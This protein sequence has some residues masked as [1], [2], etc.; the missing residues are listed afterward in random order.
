VLFQAY[1]VQYKDYIPGQGEGIVGSG[2]GIC[3]STAPYSCVNMP[4]IAPPL[5]PPVESPKA[6]VS[7]P[8]DKKSEVAT[9]SAVGAADL[10][11]IFFV[12]VAV[13]AAVIF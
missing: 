6:N 1:R 9:T 10:A 4:Q 2:W 12:V 13:A 11:T 3:N 5:P 7:I 8:I